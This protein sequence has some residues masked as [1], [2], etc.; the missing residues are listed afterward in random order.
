MQWHKRRECS[1]NV[2]GCPRRMP[3]MLHDGASYTHSSWVVL[4]TCRQSRLYTLQ[5]CLHTLQRRGELCAPKQESTA[6]SKRSCLHTFERVST[7]LS[8][9]CK[10]MYALF[11][12]NTLTHHQKT[13]KKELFE[14]VY[15]YTKLFPSDGRIFGV[16]EYSIALLYIRYSL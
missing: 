6:L 1:G 3:T 9:N 5:S 10:K 4:C 11:V 2:A 8:L 14:R 16:V 13:Q 12:Y 15:S 7:V